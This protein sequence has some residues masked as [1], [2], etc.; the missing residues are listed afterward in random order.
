[1]GDYPHE[2]MAALYWTWVDAIASASS[3]SES[4]IT[5]LSEDGGLDFV[6]AIDGRWAEGALD[7]VRDRIEALDGRLSLD[8][9]Q[10]G[11]AR[12]QGWLPLP[13]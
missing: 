4:S 10:D 8:D 6:V 1:L 2:S 13:R 3:G 9:R 5:V 11:R 12:I 7:R